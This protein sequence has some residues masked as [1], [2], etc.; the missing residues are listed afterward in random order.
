MLYR[1]LQYFQQLLNKSEVYPQRESEVEHPIYYRHEPLWYK[2]SGKRSVSSKTQACAWHFVV[3]KI[4]TKQQ[5]QRKRKN[6]RCNEGLVD[7]F[8]TMNVYRSKGLAS[9][10]I[11]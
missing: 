1:Y 4:E 9:H 5:Q 3:F 6:E 7:K 8:E 10:P 11:T 2:V